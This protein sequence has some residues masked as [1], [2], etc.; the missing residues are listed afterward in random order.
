M[1]TFPIAHDFEK[2]GRWSEQATCCYPFLDGHVEWHAGGQKRFRVKISVTI[3]S[4]EFDHFCATVGERDCNFKGAR[5]RGLFASPRFTRA[6]C[7][8]VLAIAKTKLIS[9]RKFVNDHLRAALAD[10]EGWLAFHFQASTSACS[11]HWLRRL[12][13][14]QLVHLIL[15]VVVGWRCCK[16][17]D[18]ALSAVAPNH[19]SVKSL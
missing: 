3:R 5:S 6:R 14:P 9:F 15:I 4:G 1:A 10:D 16:A 8:S 11:L 19:T 12:V 2:S 13:R 17:I 7:A 18:A